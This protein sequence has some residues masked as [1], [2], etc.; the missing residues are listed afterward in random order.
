M[1]N[2]EQLI[3]DWRQ[4]M[5]AAGIN[6][7]RTL[8]E[9]E[10][11]LREEVEDRMR[12]GLHEREAF[13]IAARRIGQPES[14]KDEFDKTGVPFVER[15]RHFV[16][17]LAGI[18]QP[19]LATNMNTTYP[20]APEPRWATY[21]KGATFVA[22]ALSLWLFCIVFLVPKLT[23]MC[24]EA[25]TSLF[26]VKGATTAYNVFATVGHA[27]IFASQHAILIGIVGIAMLILLE[28]RS[29]QWVCYRKLAVGTGMFL[30]NVAVLVS[31]TLMVLSA[32]F[33]ATN[34]H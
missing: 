24:Q 21:F 34:S 17:T 27:M 20:N 12:A 5:L 10:S 25:G 1:H 33:A 3:K 23:Q 32:I 19:E 2:L 4:Q 15:L 31:I 30:L 16:L 29:T 18:Q 9:L 26:N 6:S 7:S 8:D 11:H 22:P 14:L 13:I 28:W